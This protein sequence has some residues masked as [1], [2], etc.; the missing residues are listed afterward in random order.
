MAYSYFFEDVVLFFQITLKNH[1]HRT[2]DF[3][4]IAIGIQTC[5]KWNIGL[6]A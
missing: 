3:V 6:L 2:S 4:L 1:K 5:L